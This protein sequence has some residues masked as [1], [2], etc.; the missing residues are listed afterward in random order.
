MVELMMIDGE[1]DSRDVDLQGLRHAH[2]LSL[3]QG[4]RDCQR[5]H[6][7]GGNERRGV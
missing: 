6:Y 2:R 7:R 1:L 3:D 5:H 4:R